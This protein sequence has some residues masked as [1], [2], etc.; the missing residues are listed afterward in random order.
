MLLIGL[1]AARD[2]N[3]P[4]WTRTI[5]IT[6]PTTAMIIYFAGDS[7]SLVLWYLAQSSVPFQLSVSSL[8]ATTDGW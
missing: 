6:L 1:P 3:A 7:K 4:A 8:W 2:V 5:A